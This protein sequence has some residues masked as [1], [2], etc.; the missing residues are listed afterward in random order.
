MKTIASLVSVG[1]CSGLLLITAPPAAGDINIDPQFPTDGATSPLSLPIPYYFK[2]SWDG[3]SWT[4]E[5][6]D[7]AR[8]A[9]DYLGSFFVDQPAFVE[10]DS[11]DDF[12]IRWAGE[13]FFKDW[14]ESGNWDLNLAGGLAVAA[15]SQ[16]GSDAPWDKEKYPLGEIY[17]NKNYAWHFNPLTDPE[18]GDPN[19]PIDGEFDFWSILLHEAIHILCVNKH[20]TDP[21]AV[22]Y[23]SF[24][25]GQRRWEIKEADKQLLR[26]AG[27]EIIPAPGSMPIS[28]LALGLLA[29]LRRRVG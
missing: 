13:D 16:I 25:D 22:M 17:F 6:K 26:E 9:L 20:A 29:L 28:L 8:G 14:G 5:Q 4:T 19:D 27:Y 12:S 3:V 7:S 18:E 11:P 23:P 15:K 1:V 24:S 21:D 10:Q 2:T